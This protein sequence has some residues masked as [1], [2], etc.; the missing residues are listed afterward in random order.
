MWQIKFSL[1]HLSWSIFSRQK[2]GICGY[3]QYKQNQINNFLETDFL[4]CITLFFLQKLSLSQ[5]VAN[6]CLHALVNNEKDASESCNRIKEIY[7]FKEYFTHCILVIFLC[8]RC[9]LVQHGI[10][11]NTR[12]SSNSGYP[13]FKIYFNSILVNLSGNHP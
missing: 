11:K 12:P 8:S 6:M 3:K 2:H 9:F 13:N 10:D 7:K 4:V 5:S 1:T